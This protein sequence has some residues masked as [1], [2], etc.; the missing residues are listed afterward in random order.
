MKHL[1]ALAPLCALLFSAACTQ[2][3]QKLVAAG[4]RYHDRGKYNEASILY[5]KAIAKD[6][7]YGEAYYREGLNL[8]DSREMANTVGAAQYLRRAVD[9]QPDNADAET[10]LAEIYLTAYST[11]P[12]KFKGLLP[13]VR[14]LDTKILQHDANSFNGMRLKALLYLVDNQRD[15]ALDTFAEANRIKP[16]SPDLV[17]WYAETLG[18]AG[19]LQEAEALVRNTLNHDPKWSRGYDF[20]F[21]L[22]ARQN[23]QQ[24]AEAVLRERVQKNPTDL[25]GIENLAN[26]LLANHREDE[27]EAVIKPVL[28][29]KKAFPTGHQAVGDFYSR[30]R[31]FD[32]ALQQYQ[33]GL[34]EDPKNELL[35]DQR[36]VG[37]YEVTNRNNEALQLAKEINSKN[38]KNTVAN[39][40]YAGL[41]LRTGNPGNISK[42]LDELKTVMQNSPT[43]GVLHLDLARAYFETNQ[44]DKSLTEALNAMQYEAKAR[45]PRPQ[46]IGMARLI[47]ARIYEDRGEHTKALEQTGVLLQ[48]NPNNPEARLIRDRALIASNDI[49][50][51]QSDLEAL[52]KSVPQM[53]EARLQ[54]A[55]VYLSQKQFDKAAAEFDQV[56]KSTPPDIRG[57]LGL[58]TIKLAQ[59]HGEEATRAIDALVQKYPN[60]PNLRYQLITFQT[61]SAA[62]IA[63]SDPAHAKELFGL[64]AD[65]CKQILR[66][67]PNSLDVW[68]RLGALQGQLGQN[69][70]A[71][72]S[73]ERASNVDPHNSV[74]ELNR[75][76]LLENM[77]RKNEAAAAYNKVLGIDPENAVALNN[78]AM[79]NAENRTNLDQA[80]S[81]AQRAVRKVPNNAAISDTLGYVYYQKNLNPEALRIFRQVVDESP[82]NATFH[83]HLAMA[84]EKQGDKQAAREEAEKALKYASQPNEQN[85]I[86]SF[87]TQLG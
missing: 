34:K 40:L 56:W 77:G 41:L 38:P 59:G 45:A 8:L 70:A 5:Q 58:Q 55:S 26:Y 11:D 81:F 75:A 24:K 54:L 2:S 80:M 27:A 18:G 69:D 82:Q 71:L 30:S 51:G 20:L 1:L 13:E 61:A 50:G 79:M 19:R 37:V 87:L 74:A 67:N 62:Q 3:P 83:L 72:T 29:D 33:A 44:M 16:Y 36:I 48:G 25:V 7:T 53:H 85:K 46:V 47:A 66:T 31:K 4:N 28:N 21:M 57:F 68:L 35:Y 64:A 15:K 49:A 6:K 12:K 86:R 63:K 39:E 65:N 32:Q 43:D 10:K 84:L 17:W 23:D 73:F 42:A 60:D 22:Y 52:L 9:L 76:L 14:E 78:L